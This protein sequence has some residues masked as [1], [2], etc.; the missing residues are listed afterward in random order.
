MMNT[1]SQKLENIDPLPIA[2]ARFHPTGCGPLWPVGFFDRLSE[3]C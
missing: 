1:T 2:K 3:T